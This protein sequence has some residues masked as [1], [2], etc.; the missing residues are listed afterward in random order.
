MSATLPDAALGY[1]P[2]IVFAIVIAVLIVRPSG[3]AG[4]NRV[5]VR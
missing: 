1:E 3:L 5:A 2:A 4:T